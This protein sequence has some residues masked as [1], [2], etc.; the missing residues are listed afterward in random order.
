M[1]DHLR[2]EPAG[3]LAT[4]LATPLMPPLARARYA[5]PGTD[6]VYLLRLPDRPAIQHHLLDAL[7]P[8]LYR[9]DGHHPDDVEHR[10]IFLAGDQ[11][12]WRSSASPDGNCVS[13]CP[14]FAAHC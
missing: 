12:R 10:M 3:V 5:A 7:I 6:P 4:V 13:P 14:A 1:L 9:D 2:T 11:E 8:T